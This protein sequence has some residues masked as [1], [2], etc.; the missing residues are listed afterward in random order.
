[1]ESVCTLIRTEGSNPSLSA[2][3]SELWRQSPPRDREYPKNSGRYAAYC[4][5]F[6]ACSRTTFHQLALNFPFVSN[7]HFGS[8]VTGNILINM[9][10][11]SRFLA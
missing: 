7:A 11:L 10:F 2:I 5:V 3:K 4:G 1:M 8:S 6:F 9:E